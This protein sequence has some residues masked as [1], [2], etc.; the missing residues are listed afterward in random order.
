MFPAAI[1][2]AEVEVPCTN[3]TAALDFFTTRADFRVDLI[4]PADAPP[5]AVISAYGARLRLI[6]VQPTAPLRLTLR[7]D[8]EQRPN[9]MRHETTGPD[10]LV[11][12]Q[13]DAEPK[14]T[15]PVG[16]Q[17]WIIIWNNDANTSGTGHAGMEYRDLIPGRSSGRFVASRI[18]I[19][20]GGEV[21]DYVY[22]HRVRFRIVLCEVASVLIAALQP[23]S[24]AQIQSLD[25]CQTTAK[26]VHLAR[27]LVTHKTAGR[28]AWPSVRNAKTH[29]RLPQPHS[30]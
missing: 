13:V 14:I 9:F 22:F 3:L 21:P 4:F 18:R 23:W 11:I 10:N 7:V 17:E 29:T 12:A 28:A 5:T 16:T 6:A 15:V 20:D 8:A 26:S 19:P 27:S 1:Q 2:T 30:A 24:S 25:C